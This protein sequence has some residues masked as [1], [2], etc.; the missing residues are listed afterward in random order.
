MG[1]CTYCA[2]KHAHGPLS[3]KPLPEILK[4]FDTGLQQGFKEFKIVA[5]DTGSYGQDI[6]TNIVELLKGLLNRCGDFRL[7]ILDIN[8]AFVVQYAP[9]LIEILSRSAGKIRCMMI[10]IQSGNDDIL[11][12]MKRDYNSIEVKECLYAL[13]KASPEMAIATHV[14]VGFPGESENQFEDTIRFLKT[15]NFDR[16]DIYKYDDRPNTV[17]C[18]FPNQVPNHIKEI[19]VAKLLEEFEMTSHIDIN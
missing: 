16:I 6:G 5:A 1:S 2:I 12:L 8:P 4:E 18:Q 19:R 15:V 3:S 11:S 13:R 7:S 14:I 10:P 17:A 9:D